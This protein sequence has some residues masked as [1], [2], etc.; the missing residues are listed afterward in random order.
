MKRMLTVLL[1]LGSIG[2]GLAQTPKH[3]KPTPSATLLQGIWAESKDE[4]AVFWVRG[5]RLVYTDFQDQLLKYSLTSTTLTIFQVD[6]PDTCRIRKLTR[7]SLVLVNT[8]RSVLR[9]YKR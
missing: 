2:S 6:G 3:R 9:L 8:A 7:D 4:N 5:N 1:V